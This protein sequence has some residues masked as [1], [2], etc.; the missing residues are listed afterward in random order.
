MYEQPPVHEGVYEYVRCAACGGHTA[1]SRIIPPNVKP[2]RCSRV[3]R[4]GKRSLAVADPEGRMTLDSI[5][6]PHESVIKG[7]RRG[8]QLAARETKR[9]LLMYGQP[10]RGKTHLAVA[11]VRECEKAGMR[12]GYFNIVNLIADIQNTYGQR[13]GEY[14][15]KTILDD[16]THNEVIGIDDL[17]KEQDTE[18]TRNIV[19]QLINDASMKEAVLL[20]STN[21]TPFDLKGRYDSA[22]L[23][24]MKAMTS[25][26]HVEGKDMREDGWEWL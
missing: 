5:V 10:G 25:G 17:G 11:I 12:A 19:Y 2:C 24:R 16:V 8:R 14:T 15:R 26:L 22:V 6:D 21:M 18:N 13:D 23:S 1:G 7:M 20:V 9:G 4:F 3:A